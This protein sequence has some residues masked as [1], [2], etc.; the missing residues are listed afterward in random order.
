[1]VRAFI[2]SG[3][4]IGHVAFLK[5]FPLVKAFITGDDAATKR[6]WYIQKLYFS[7]SSVSN[8]ETPVAFEFMITPGELRHKFRKVRSIRHYELVPYLKSHGSLLKALEEREPVRSTMLILLNG[9]GTYLFECPTTTLINWRNS[10]PT[11]G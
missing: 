6:N 11:I 1:M 9:S 8:K 5:L 4:K 3:N 2:F 10:F 7:Y